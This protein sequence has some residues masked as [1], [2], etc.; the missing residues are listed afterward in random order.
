MLEDTSF[1]V[2]LNKYF[3]VGAGDVSCS[4]DEIIQYATFFCRT[5]ARLQILKVVESDG[6]IARDFTHVGAYLADSYSTT[7]NATFCWYVFD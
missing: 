7:T 4:F 2:H 5:S 3:K 1:K 6:L